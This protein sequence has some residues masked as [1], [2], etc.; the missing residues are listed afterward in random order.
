MFS[1]LAVYEPYLANVAQKS[2]HNCANSTVFGNVIGFAQKSKIPP[3]AVGGIIQIQ[4]TRTSDFAEQRFR[5]DGGQFPVRLD[6]NAST[7]FRWW[8]CD[9]FRQA[10]VMTVKL[11]WNAP[12][13]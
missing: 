9:L 7:N 6:L 11:Y 3:K 2:G 1:S 13:V 4:P 12:A 8:D 10:N 5:V